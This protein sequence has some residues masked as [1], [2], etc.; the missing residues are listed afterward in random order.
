MKKVFLALMAVAAIAL[1]SCQKDLSVVS[2]DYAKLCDEVVG[3]TPAAAEEVL[4]KAGW[5]KSE[6]GYFVQKKK[7]AALKK[8][9]EDKSSKN[10]L[11]LG[12]VIVIGYDED[13]CLA[14]EVEYYVGDLNSVRAA[15]VGF[16]DHANNHSGENI[17]YKA[18]VN[19][20]EYKE[21]AAFIEAVKNSEIDN[22]KE[23]FTKKADGYGA[24]GNKVA[25]DGSCYVASYYCEHIGD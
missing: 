22:V 10:L 18:S 4:T 24:S 5:V 21:H 20:K 12:A 25:E 6:T 15:I 13:K 8:A 17:S 2:I 1:T 19:G 9:L 14:S 23:I 7:E 11:D 16:A 3:M